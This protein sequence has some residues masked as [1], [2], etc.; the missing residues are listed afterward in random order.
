MSKSSQVAVQKAVQKR[1]VWT[2]A[3]S[4]AEAVKLADVDVIA[5]Y[6]IRPYTGI[7]NALATM[8]AGG[9][10]YAEYLVCD[11]EHSQFEVVKHASAVGARTFVGSSGTGLV[12]GAEA[13]V[14]TA[15]GQ[16]PVVGIVGCRSLDDPGNFG[17]EWNDAFMFRDVGWLMEWSKDPQEA[18]EMTLVAYRIAEDPRVLLPHFVAL[19]GAAITHVAS[20]VTPPTKEQVA[21]FLPPYKPLHPLDPA[22][23]SVS[24]AMHI[25]PSLIGPEQRKSID[26]AMKR[27]KNIVIPEAWKAWGDTIGREYPPFFEGTQMEDADYAILSMGAYSRNVEYVVERMRESGVKVGSLRLKYLRPFPTEELVKALDG[28]KGI[29]VVD[30]S[31][32]FGSPGNGSVLYNDVRA[33]FYEAEQ[34]PLIMDYIFAGGREMTIPELE[35][36]IQALIESVRKGRVDKPVRWV[37]VRGEDV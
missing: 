22:Y 26:A 24:K 30:F 10:F 36:S 17:M 19:D 25:A 2:G 12:Y 35:K 31:Y 20:P 8:I 33:A 14:V 13:A 15:L 18:L 16:L 29:G 28:V 6:P 11:S 1:R 5:A 3:R 34:R 23:E 9:D 37:T 21:K 27:A 32:S 4:V 7:M